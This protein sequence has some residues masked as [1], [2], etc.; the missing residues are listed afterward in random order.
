[1]FSY[2]D[3]LFVLKI[4][5]YFVYDIFFSW[6]KYQY[7]S[8]VEDIKDNYNELKQELFSWSPETK[9]EDVKTLLGETYDKV[10][11]MNPEISD[12]KT[13]VKTKNLFTAWLSE[14]MKKWDY[15]KLLNWLKFKFN[16][17][18]SVLL[19]CARDYWNWDEKKLKKE[20]KLFDKYILDNLLEL[21]KA[22]I[23]LMVTILHPEFNQQQRRYIIN[24]MVN[25]ID[26]EKYIP[27]IK[28]FLNNIDNRI[29]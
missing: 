27:A 4:A 29:I 8:L 19:E 15:A 22:Y 28:K 13:M 12:I 7:K 2:K 24:E 5:W 20:R 21:K 18:L 10:K 3:L 6:K 26:F 23:D 9:N 11:L 16:S 17:Y 25:K 14:Y 1:M